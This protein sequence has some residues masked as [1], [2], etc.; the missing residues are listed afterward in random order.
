MM[1]QEA[2][3]INAK[4]PDHTLYIGVCPAKSPAGLYFKY[5]L[6]ISVL[7]QCDT[8]SVY[9]HRISTRDA[10]NLEQVLEAGL[11]AYFAVVDNIVTFEMNDFD[12]VFE[13]DFQHRI[14]ICLSCQYAI[15]PSQAKT[16]LQVYHKRLT[17][18]QRRDIIS[19]VEGTTQLARVREDVIYPEPTEPPVANLPVY[20][21]GLKCTG[22]TSQGNACSYMC[23]TLHPMQE[24]CK[25]KHNWTNQQRRG[26]DTRSEQLHTSNKIWTE[27]HSCQRFFKVGAW[28]RYHE[29][30][31]REVE[32]SD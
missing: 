27:N 31:R 26:G 8:A 21:D 12:R 20:F 17:V 25:Q 15:I 1:R 2:D 29:V 11:P 19:K 3:N 23:R 22:I 18:Q 7:L 9:K 24:H 28:Q 32:R 4:R 10:F 16:Y 6:T 14:L 30:A 13:T 5:S